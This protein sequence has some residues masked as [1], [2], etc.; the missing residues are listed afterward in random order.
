ME[1]LDRLN[2]SISYIEDT[3]AIISTK[4]DFIKK[5]LPQ[6][7]NVPSIP[8][9]CEKLFINRTTATKQKS[10]HK[11]YCTYE[12]FTSIYLVTFMNGQAKSDG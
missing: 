8:L 3:P 4:S 2:Q 12:R 7:Y 1:W 10:M 5:E 11:I 6:L 9:I